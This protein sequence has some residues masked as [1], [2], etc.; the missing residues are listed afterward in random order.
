MPSIPSRAELVTELAELHRTQLKSLTDATY[1][2]WTREQLVA[3]Q[4][5]SDRISILQRELNAL[6]GTAGWSHSLWS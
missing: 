6:D 2:G 1:V 4:K 3:Q 5:R